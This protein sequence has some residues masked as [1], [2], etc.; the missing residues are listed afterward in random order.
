MSAATENSDSVVS[1][2][3]QGSVAVLTLQRRQ[4]QRNELRIAEA[5]RGPP[6]LTLLSRLTR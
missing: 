6:S 5:R 1:L 3:L 2:E 4:R